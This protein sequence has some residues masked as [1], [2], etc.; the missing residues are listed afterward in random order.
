MIRADDPATPDALADEVFARYKDGFVIEELLVNA[1]EIRAIYPKALNTCRI[2]AIKNGDEVRIFHPVLRIGRGGAEIDSATAAGGIMAVVDVETGE[3]L[4]ACDESLNR[5]E[6][7]PDTGAQIVGFKIPRWDEAI[8][9]VKEIATVLE[10][11]HYAGWD[12]ALTPDGWKMIE[13]NACGMFI[14]QMPM[15]RGFRAELEQICAD[16]NFTY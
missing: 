13:G 16:L 11:Q 14:W 12:L 9:L 6:K 4:A 15:N 1:P 2:P 5:Y 3:L 10:G 8:A 7:H